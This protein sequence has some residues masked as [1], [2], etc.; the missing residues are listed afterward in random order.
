MSK[1]EN[2][3]RLEITQV[4]HLLYQKEFICASDGNVSVRLASDRFLITPSGLHKGLLTT[5][6]ILLVDGS[7]Q[8]VETAPADSSLKPTSEL[9]MHLEAYRQR[10][11]ITA[12]VHAHPPTAVALSIAGIDLAPYLLPEVIVFLGR[13]PTTDYATPSSP[14]NAEAIRQLIGHHDGLV[15]KRHGALTVGNS[16]LQ[17]FMR[18]ETLEQQ[19]RILFKLHQLGEQHLDG[20]HPMPAADVAKLLQMRQQMGLM[21]DGEMETFRQLYGIQ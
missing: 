9:P 14:E 1:T 8:I 10:A 21:H 13:I 20:A 18:M 16:P 2:S 6:Q 19:A 7:G 15:L 5:D 4:C 3:L 12:V 17:A 11:D